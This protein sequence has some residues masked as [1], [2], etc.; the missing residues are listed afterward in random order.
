VAG[1]WRVGEALRLPGSPHSVVCFSGFHQGFSALKDD[2][3]PR[4]FL[5]SKNAHLPR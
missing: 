2:Q 4:I 3:G 5:V 1:D